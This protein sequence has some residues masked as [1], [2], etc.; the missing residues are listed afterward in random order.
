MKLIF[1]TECQDVVKLVKD[2]IKKCKC[3]RCSGKYIDGLNAWYSGDSVI[4]LGFSNPSF[5]EAIHKQP[6]TG[7]GKLFSAFV[8]PK[9]CDTFKFK[10]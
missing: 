9:E 10:K 2:K 5:I 4:P 7:L 6:E 1:C 8:I 3:G